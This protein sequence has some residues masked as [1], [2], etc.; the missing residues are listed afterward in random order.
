MKLG[1]LSAIKMR[2]RSRQKFST[3]HKKQNVT[4]KRFVERET[5]FPPVDFFIPCFSFTIPIDTL[6]SLEEGKEC[7]KLGTTSTESQVVHPTST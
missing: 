1:K 6:F 4:R 3:L 2:L 5:L 7:G